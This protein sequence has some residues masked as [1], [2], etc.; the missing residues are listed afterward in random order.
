MLVAELDAECGEFGR[1]RGH[2]DRGDP[3]FA[4]GEA[5]HG[6]SRAALR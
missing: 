6:F 3:P 5:D 2:V 4:D 1:I